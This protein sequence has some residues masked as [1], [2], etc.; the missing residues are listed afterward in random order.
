MNAQAKAPF[1]VLEA[2]RADPTALVLLWSVISAPPSHQAQTGT[3]A[4]EELRRRLW[5]ASRLLGTGAAAPAR[6]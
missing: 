4:G 5:A 1:V 6:R 2:G 3:E